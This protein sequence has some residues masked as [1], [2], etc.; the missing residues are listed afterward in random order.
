MEEI[1]A[2]I[3]E[4]IASDKGGEATKSPPPSPTGRDEEP[5]ELESPLPSTGRQ[6]DYVRPPS[7]SRSWASPREAVKRPTALRSMSEARLA[8]STI[9]AHLTSSIED[10]IRK[11]V[12]DR[13]MAALIEDV[14]KKELPTLAEKIVKRVLREIF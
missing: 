7:S 1:L 2:S 8:E 3:R 5:L 9:E 14:L 12:Q 6:R 11:A 13:R 10:Y 4:I